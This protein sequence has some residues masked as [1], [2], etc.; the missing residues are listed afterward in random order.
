MREIGKL[1]KYNHN[2]LEVWGIITFIIRQILKKKK[3]EGRKRTM[4][5]KLFMWRL[6]ELFG[7]LWRRWIVRLRS[8]SKFKI[9]FRPQWRLGG[10]K[11]LL[12]A[13]F[14]LDS[15]ILIWFGRFFI[16]QR[17]LSDLWS[18]NMV[19]G[20]VC[21]GIIS[22]ILK[23]P[24][25]VSM[26]AWCGRIGGDDPG[27]VEIRLLGSSSLM[28]WRRLFELGF[29]S[30][31]NIHVAAKGLCIGET[32][33]TKSA[34]IGSCRACTLFIRGCLVWVFCCRLISLHSTTWENQKKTKMRRGQVE[35]TEG[36]FV[37]IYREACKY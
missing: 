19:T 28:S 26:A 7:G 14:N 6:K 4:V 18:D 22:I 31:M 17:Q 20:F 5:Y 30:T 25:P 16:K 13:L 37:Y 35:D 2:Y 23:K 29:V 10:W 36:V 21:F 33:L 34:V 24:T 9:Q 32:S 27:G 1:N 15:G 11:P 3:Q 12:N 8:Q